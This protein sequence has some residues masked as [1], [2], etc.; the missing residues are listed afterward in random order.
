MERPYQQL[1]FREQNGV[2]CVRLKDHKLAEDG[3]EQMCAEL[4]RLI[5]E[6]GCRKMV[7][8]LGPGDLECL[9]SVF[10][11]KLVNLQRRLDGVGGAMALA[12]VSENTQDVFR[13]TG[14]ERYFRFYP[15]EASAVQGLV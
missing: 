9:Y 4:A 15:D 11:A 1:E 6:E 10:L 12:A 14:L 8:N 3:L 2:F 13:A 5:D 7:L